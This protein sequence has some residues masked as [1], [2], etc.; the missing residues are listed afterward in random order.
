MAI[1]ND[2]VSTVRK[3]LAPVLKNDFPTQLDDDA[4]AIKHLESEQKT[5]TASSHMIAQ[6][7]SLCS[8]CCSKSTKH[9]SC[10]SSLCLQSI[11]ILNAVNKKLQHHVN[12]DIPCERI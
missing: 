10:I 9:A 2:S 4:K 5:E 12:N 7:K 8:S 6:V 3:A 1:L 11:G